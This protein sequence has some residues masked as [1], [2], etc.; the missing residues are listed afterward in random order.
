MERGWGEHIGGIK[1]VALLGATVAGLQNR[2]TCTVPCHATG[3]ITAVCN[4][5]A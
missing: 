1:R 2:F 5:I 4:Y 3:Q